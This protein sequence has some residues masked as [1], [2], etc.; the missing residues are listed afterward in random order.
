MYVYYQGEKAML[1]LA[2][3]IAIVTVRIIVRWTQL[4]SLPQYILYSFRT[5]LEV[6]HQN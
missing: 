4:V 3:L 1:L 2:T 5:D 6:L